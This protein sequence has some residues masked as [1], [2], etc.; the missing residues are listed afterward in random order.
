[1]GEG[2]R[3]F[4]PGGGE[5]GRREGGEDGKREGGKDEKGWIYKKRM[6]GGRAGN[7]GMKEGGAS[8]TAAHHKFS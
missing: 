2:G 7:E 6:E 1:M 8:Q 4:P 5:D 3:G